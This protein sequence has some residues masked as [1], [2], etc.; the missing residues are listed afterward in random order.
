MSPLGETE[1]RV[2][3]ILCVTSCNCLW[4]YN[5]LNKQSPIPRLFNWEPERVSLGLSLMGRLWDISIEAVSRQLV[6]WNLVWMYETN[7]QKVKAVIKFLIWFVPNTYLLPDPITS[8]WHE[9]M[10][11]FF[12]FSMINFSKALT[13]TPCPPTMQ[14]DFFPGQP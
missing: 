7:E 2:Y 8:Q 4:I 10:S 11:F 12:F 5:V 6:C 3:G 1:W 13:N 9:G 14:I